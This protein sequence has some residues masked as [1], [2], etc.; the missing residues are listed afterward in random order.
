MYLIDFVDVG[1]YLMFIYNSKI[2]KI[3]IRINA[4][5]SEIKNLD[6]YNSASNC[7]NGMKF[8]PCIQG[9]TPNKLT[10]FQEKKMVTARETRPQI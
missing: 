8:A 5:L 3:F 9:S 10:K 6:D 7:R 1:I 4:N 2:T